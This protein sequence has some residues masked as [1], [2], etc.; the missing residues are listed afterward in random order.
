[1]SN[2]VEPTG[3]ACLRC[4]RELVSLGSPNFR[5]GGTGGLGHVLLGSWADLG[6][7]TVEFQ[8]LACDTCGHVELMLTEKDRARL[9]ERRSG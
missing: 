2:D 8:V 3:V 5:I 4:H 1:M 9:A 6:E 7:T